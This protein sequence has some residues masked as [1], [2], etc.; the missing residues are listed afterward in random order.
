MVL[1]QNTLILILIEQCGYQILKCDDI[2]LWLRAFV[3][4]FA[5]LHVTMAR[6]EN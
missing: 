6:V 5:R 2:L 1:I 3:P 4:Y